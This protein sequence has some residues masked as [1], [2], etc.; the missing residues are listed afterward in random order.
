MLGRVSALSEG[1]PQL[2]NSDGED[3]IAS[4]V[5]RSS[6][7]SSEVTPG[8]V[9][10]EIQKIDINATRRTSLKTLV[11]QMTTGPR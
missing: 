3:D 4:R 8:H 1:G 11:T 5:S 2:H 6:I 9:G 10:A 7:A